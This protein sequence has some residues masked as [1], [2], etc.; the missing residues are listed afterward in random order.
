MFCRWRTSGIWERLLQRGGF[1]L[2]VAD[3]INVT[4][5]YDS[6]DRLMLDL[7]HMGEANA[8]AARDRH[9]TRPGLFRRAADLYAEHFPGDQKALRASFEL[10]VL[11]GWAPADSQPKPLRPGSARTRLADALGTDE[12]PLPD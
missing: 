8:L 12:T 2:P 3:A 10:L 9:M 5:E 7:R 6:L 4:A 11:T 1:A